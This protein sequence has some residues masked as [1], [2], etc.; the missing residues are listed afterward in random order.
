[1][2]L[3]KRANPYREH[4]AE[5]VATE[6]PRLVK[7]EPGRYLTITGDS[8]PGGED[9]EHKARALL[10]VAHTVQEAKKHGGRDFN[11]GKLEALWWQRGRERDRQ[12]DRP[13]WHWKLM[14]RVPDF[15]S[16][17]DL[18]AA[19]SGGRDDL[20]RDVWLETIDEG[21]CVQVLHVGPYEGEQQTVERMAEFARLEGRTFEGFHHEIYLTSPD[22]V[23]PEQLR[24]I[25]RHQVVAAPIAP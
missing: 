14:V 15:V 10:R 5:Y 25:L 7:T 18:G 11:L 2:G 17:Q 8:E 3:S 23:P 4:Q 1:M 12:T 6:T 9:F 20:I 13:L 16:E 21:E 24:T 22:E 19:K